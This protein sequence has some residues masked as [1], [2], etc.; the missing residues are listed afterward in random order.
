MITQLGYT[1]FECSAPEILTRAECGRGGLRK[2]E[3]W[4][5]G[6]RANPISVGRKGGAM[7]ERDAASD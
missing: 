5:N 7:E 1:S 6:M 4:P 2:A 3:L